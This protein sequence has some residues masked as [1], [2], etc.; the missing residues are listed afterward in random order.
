M[1]EPRQTLPPLEWIRVFETAARL[2]SFTAA[3]DELG[4]T[5]AA[6]SQR[7]RNL[8]L[9]L[10]A[11]LFNRLP[12]GV[13]LSTQGEAWLPD[14]QAALDRLLHSAATLFEAPRRKITVA[15][16]ASV[17]ELWIV[18]RLPLVARRLPHVQL[19]F[20]TIQNL[21]DYERSEADFEIRF[22]EGGWPGRE[23]RRL[24]AEELAPV[25]AP[26]LLRTAADWQ[27]LPRIAVAGP[28]LGWRDWSN[29]TGAEPPPAPRLR[30][31][32]FVQALRAAEA[33]AGVLLASLALCGAALEAGTLE[34]LT[35]RTLRMEAGYWVSWARSR[36]DFAER[37]PL[38]E[39]LAA[40]GGDA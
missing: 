40:H 23:A 19:A 31:D 38:L 4:L 9:R 14:V 21:P 25:A 26:A 3:A 22:G 20:E 11:Q 16:S 34:R 27:A 28:R 5:Q 33:G 13:A 15:A 17:I 32:T 35:G 10:G 18:P 29:A 8:E 39:C 24:F 30:F 12:R 1:A 2:G 36:P 37:L 6:V 7:I